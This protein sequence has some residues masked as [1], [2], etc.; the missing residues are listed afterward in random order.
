MFRTNMFEYCDY[1]RILK[2]SEYHNVECTK[3]DKKV[4]LIS[5][6]L[7][8]ILIIL[9]ECFGHCPSISIDANEKIIYV[10]I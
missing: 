4:A 8:N 10:N 9:D 7:E 3:N 6:T 1:E 2:C 5:D